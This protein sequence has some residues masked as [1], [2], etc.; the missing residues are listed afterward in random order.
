[1]NVKQLTQNRVVRNANWMVGEQL[2]QM[3]I[4]FFIGII[5]TRYLGP[6]NYG[7]INYCAAYVAF[8]SSVCSLGL[9]GVL[10]KELV[11]HPENEGKLVGTSLIMRLASGALSVGSI[12]LILFFV[13][14][15]N[16]T[17]MTVGLLQSLV[18]LFK[19]FEVM[20]FWFQSKLQSRHVAI[21]KMISYIAV[22]A[23][24][25]FILAT[26]KSVEWF[27]FSTSLD[28]LIIALLLIFVYRKNDGPRLSFS[29]ETATYLIKNSYHFILSAFF[30][31]I[32]TQ[33][34]K[35]MISK[36]LDD[37]QTGYYSIA[38]TIFGYW[39]LVTTAIT[40][41]SRPSI[42]S[43]K[44]HDEELYLRRLKQLYAILF[45]LSVAAALFFT[46]FGGYLIPLVYGAKYLPSGPSVIITMW[47]A[48]FSVLG[49]ARGIWIICENK[50]RYVKYF[51]IIG[52]FANVALNAVF[53]PLIGIEGA[54]IA[55]FITQILTCL[56]APMFYKE[57]R[58]HTKYVLEACFFKGV[59][60]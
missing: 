27:A 17:V 47:Y 25:V 14:S 36:F 12:C 50:N 54:A 44:G 60:K 56:I 11:T 22:A 30:V 1:M 55:T 32:Y 7:V 33:M 52:A 8:F 3:A 46:L 41:A 2:V 43:K 58:V 18:L 59:L 16:A 42:M 21:V 24:K 48:P 15:G 38:T 35:I 40:N 26:G 9:E 20:D 51:V 39:V 10:V 57:T 49:T 45:W 53:I 31:T 28:F 19:A 37:T 34:D 29:S 23:Y 4:S 13:D 6:A 5:T